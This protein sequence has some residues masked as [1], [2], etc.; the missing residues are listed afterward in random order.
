MRASNQCAWTH[1][2]Q[3]KLPK[4]VGC[5]ARGDATAAASA[6]TW[7]SFAG[8]SR[9]M[10][11]SAIRAN[12]LA[13][14]CES[15][16]DMFCSG[17]SLRRCLILDLLVRVSR[18]L[19]LAQSGPAPQGQIARDDNAPSGRLAARALPF[20]GD[21]MALADADR[22]GRDLRQ[23]VVGNEFDRVL[24]RELNGRRQGDGFILAG[25]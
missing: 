19:A 14:V 20:V 11:A 2:C 24:E 9:S 10:F 22:L 4:N 5:S 7:S 18:N 17:R 3:S 23:L 15:V 12:R 8:N 25:G 6:M 21:Q 16:V 13:S 1:E